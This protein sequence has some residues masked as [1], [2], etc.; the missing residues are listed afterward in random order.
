MKKF[1]IL[2]IT[3][4]VLSGTVLFGCGT[5]GN[6]SSSE[7]PPA[8]PPAE[9]TMETAPAEVFTIPDY[10]PFVADVQY[11]YSATWEAADYQVYNAYIRG[12]AV[13]RLVSG[14]SRDSVEVLEYKDGAL[15]MQ[16]GDPYYYFY[17]DITDA[18]PNNDRIVLM[19]PLVVGT[20][21]SE[22]SGEA[23]RIT[24][25]D[26]PV[27]TPLGSYAALEVTVTPAGGGGTQLFYYAKG[28]GLVKFVYHLPEFDVVGT[29]SAVYPETG[30]RRAAE[31]YWPS[32]D[33]DNRSEWRTEIR[34]LVLRTNGDFA[35][36]I[37]EELKDPPEG[38]ASA[39]PDDARILG[40]GIDRSTGIA[41]IEMSIAT[42]E[43]VWQA[44]ANVV[45]N[46]YDADQVRFVAD[47]Q[48]ITEQ[49]AVERPSYD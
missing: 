26:A 19:E 1:S 24:S 9:I 33:K 23:S 14:P 43:I 12:N 10:F 44:V 30:L 46:F 15:R 21:W 25:L 40:I 7:T 39:L 3:A 22:A 31:F 11:E 2:I 27:E 16:F 42:D 41:Y 47:G 6:A 34:A 35:P 5:G 18:E 20:E 48:M 37:E 45:G 38:A 36:Q 49:V 32:S 29:L 4:C 13:Q 8:E 17:E 28:I